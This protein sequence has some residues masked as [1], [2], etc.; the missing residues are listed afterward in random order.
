VAGP[1]AGALYEA[2]ATLPP[3]AAVAALLRIAAGTL[4]D[5]ESAPFFASTEVCW[6]LKPPCGWYLLGGAAGGALPGCV[7]AG[8]GL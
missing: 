3:S 2:C 1:P 4:A 5:C 6:K 8:G 7:E